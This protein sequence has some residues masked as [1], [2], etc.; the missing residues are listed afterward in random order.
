MYYC[1]VSVLHCIFI[2]SIGIVVPTTPAEYPLPLPCSTFSSHLDAFSASCTQ[3]FPP[4]PHPTFLPYSPASSTKCY[5]HPFPFSRPP[6]ASSAAAAVAAALQ[7]SYT[8]L[9][10]ATSFSPV[11]VTLIFLKANT[12]TP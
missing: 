12:K 8:M 6:R 11:Y 10:L 4:P 5:T 1:M 3:L 9:T 2:R 7:P